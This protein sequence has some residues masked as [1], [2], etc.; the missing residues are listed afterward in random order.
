M[1]PCGPVGATVDGL[2][3]LCGCLPPS[4]R[5]LWDQEMSCYTFLSV[6]SPCGVYS[7]GSGAVQLVIRIPTAG[8]F[9]L[10]GKVKCLQNFLQANFCKLKHP[11]VI[12]LTQTS[13]I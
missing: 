10:T 6:S 3:P 1:L 7:N 9:S 2:R 13:R 5:P 4:L 12:V 11:L 8:S